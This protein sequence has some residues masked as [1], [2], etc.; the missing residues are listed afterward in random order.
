MPCISGAAGR[1][2]QL[3]GGFSPP[4]AL[5]SLWHPARQLQ[6][7]TTLCFFLCINF[8][9]LTAVACMPEALKALIS[10]WRRKW[11]KN[12]IWNYVKGKDEALSWRGIETVHTFVSVCSCEVTLPEHL[13]SRVDMCL[14]P[15]RVCVRSEAAVHVIQQL[16]SSH[17]VNTDPCCL[18]A[19][20]FCF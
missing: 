10:D 4:R 3:H 14:L 7:G 17:Q 1:P 8:F 12:G 19:C 9:I 20:A 13:R 16:R 6:P 5:I 15:P 2:L 11:K 18:R